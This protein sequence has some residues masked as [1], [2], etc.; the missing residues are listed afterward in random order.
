MCFKLVLDYEV[1][2]INCEIITDSQDLITD[3]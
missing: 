1:I 2:K 3:H